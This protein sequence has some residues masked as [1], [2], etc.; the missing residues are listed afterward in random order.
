MSLL[1]LEGLT[2]SIGNRPVLNGVSLSLERGEVLALAGKSGSGKSTTALAIASLLPKSPR[3]KGAI[4]LDGTNLITQTEAELCDIRGKDIGLVF[5][6]P[7]TALNPVK[8]IGE[9][10]AETLLVHCRASRNEVRE[11]VFAILNRVG[12]SESG[13]TPDRYPHELS[14]GQRQRVAIAIAIVGAPKLVIADEPTTA[15][16]VTTQAQILDLLRKLVREDHV[17]LILIT[18][19]LA[20]VAERA[21]RVAVMQQGAIVEEGDTLSVLRAP[22]HPSTRALIDDLTR[23]PRRISPSLADDGILLEVSNLARDYDLGVGILRRG[24]RRVIEDVSFTVRRGESL[25][26]VGE[27]G[28]GKTTL[29]RAVLGLDRPNGGEVR[30]GGASVARATGDSMRTLRRKIQA[31]FQ[32]PLSSFNPRHRIER[33]IAEPLHLTGVKLTAAERLAKVHASLDKVGLASS[34]ADR[35]PHEF[36]GGQRQRIAIARALIIEPA[37]IALDE[38]VSALDASARAQILELLNTLSHELGVSYLFVTHDLSLVRAIADRL[39][40]MQAGRIVESGRTDE[41]LAA[42]KH[43]Y[44]ATLLAAT[45]NLDRALEAP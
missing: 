13:V 15:L 43:P 31:V 33:I 14:G 44:T 29:L 18:H 36:S 42:P 35:Y 7:M 16:D 39:I 23:L 32:D 11:K 9:Q 45:P 3:V 40:V 30:L 17:G 5:Q 28:S 2:V 21:D 10:I 27:F 12:L 41:I 26:V 1:K 25:G 22:Q 20:V 8:T 19:D 38:A 34:A 24:T 4:W 37:L 6:E